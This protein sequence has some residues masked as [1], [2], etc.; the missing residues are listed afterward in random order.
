MGIKKTWNRYLQSYRGLPGASWMLALVVLINRSGSMVLV[1][2]AL[3]M[4]HEMGVS[5]AQ[6][7]LT[8]SLYGIGGMAGTVAGGFLADKL[9][10]KRVQWISLLLNG[11]GFIAL[12]HLHSTHTIQAMMVAIGVVAEAFRPAN[13]AAVADSCPQDQLARGYALNRLAVNIGSTIGPAVGGVLVLVGYR[14]LFWVDGL[15]CLVA[16]LVLLLFYHEPSRKES[17]ENNS[18]FTTESALKDFPFLLFLLV[19]LCYGMLFMQLLSTFPLFMDS[20]Y[21]LHATAIGLLFALNAVICATVEMPIITRFR[22]V[23]PLRMVTVGIL[24]FVLGFVLLPF[25]SSGLFA[26]FT[27]VLWTIGEILSFPQF[28]AMVAIRAGKDRRGRYM[29]LYSLSFTI[30]LVLGPAVGGIVYEKLGALPLWLSYIPVGLLMIAVLH[31]AAK[32]MFQSPPDGR[33]SVL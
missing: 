1:F 21:G 23:A 28:S 18:S 19:L 22:N 14:F 5:P 20:A 31:T 9:G 2:M 11:L 29:G 16:A 26:A 30:A 3:Y 32:P 25:G 27:V 7:A 4:V 15:T 24:F 13:A 8:I 6:A 33:R 12:A 10:Y 17:H